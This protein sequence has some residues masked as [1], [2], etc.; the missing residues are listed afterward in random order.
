MRLPSH[1]RVV[2]T[3]AGSGLGRALC[4]AVADRKARVVVSDRDRDGA[5][6]TARL[7]RERGSEAIVV[8]CD[9]TKVDEVEG[10]ARAADDAYGGTDLLCN[11]AGIG[12]GGPVGEVSIDIWHKTIDVDLYGVIYGCHVF[13][14]RMKKAGGGHIL[15]VASAAA[16]LLAPRMGPY[17]VAKAGVLALTETLEGELAGTGVGV[18]VLCPTFFPT[19]IMRDGLYSSSGMRKFGQKMMERAKMTAGDVARLCIAGVEAGDLHIV[20]MADGRWLWRLKRVS[21]AVYR[22]LNRRMAQQ[23]GKRDANQA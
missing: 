17:N 1:P 15:N 14:P 20:P 16:L 7:V 23:M 13:V 6:E 8:L 19:N 2:V 12:S 18:S 22:F 9:V 3:G 11:N 21:P 5:E 4:L 10:L